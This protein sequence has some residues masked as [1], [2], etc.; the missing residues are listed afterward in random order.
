MIRKLTV[1]VF[2]LPGLLAGSPAGA[3]KL[4]RDPFKLPNEFTERRDERGV[5]VTVAGERPKI[6][7]ILMAGEESLVNLGGKVI[8]VGEE[9]SGYELLEIGE[10]RAVFRHGDEIVTLSLYPDQD[11]ETNDD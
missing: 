9:A 6:I 11:D 10:E 1:L 7:G 3:Y 4:Q 5:T 8:A 2:L